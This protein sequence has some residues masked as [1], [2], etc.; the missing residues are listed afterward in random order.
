MKIV[1]IGNYGAG[2]LG[3]EMILEGLLNTVKN[4]YPKSEIAVL[5]GNP[6]HTEEAHDVDSF[7]KFPAGIKSLFRFLKTK[8]PKIVQKSDLVILGGGGLFGSLSFHANIIWAIQALMAYYYKKPL[9][10]YGQSVGTVKNSLIKKILKKIFNKA[11]FIAV[12][13]Q[14]SIENLQEIGVSQ[15][16]H[17]MPD[18]A[19][20]KELKNH[21]NK[22]RT[23]IISLRQMAG[24]PKDFIQEIAEFINWLAEE[25]DY[26]VEIIDFQKG[27]DD[28]SHLSRAVLNLT[29]SAN[30]TYPD[31]DNLEDLYQHF[32]AASFVV[33]VRLHSIITALKTKTPF[34]AISYNEKVANFLDTAGFDY[35]N[36]EGLSFE[37]L[38]NSFKNPPKINEIEEFLKNASKNHRETENLL[39]QIS[40]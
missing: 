27:H 33:G 9:I 18:L 39:R 19:F 17:L 24:L 13:D 28:D 30:I 15:K 34:A 37:K 20:S 25:Q 23:V 11:K 35:L 8:T 38:K 29:N 36:L 26:H 16:I 21:G 4:V 1:L 2:N 14:K 12:R 6:S 32:A 3:D 31:I 40:L 5:S 10:M 7:P 22:D